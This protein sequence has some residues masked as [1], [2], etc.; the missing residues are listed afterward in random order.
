MNTLQSLDSLFGGE[1]D[2]SD[3]LI[4]GASGGMLGAAYFRELYYEKIKGTKIN[5]Q[6]K[7]Y[8]ENISKDLLQPAVL[9]FCYT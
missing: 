2:G 7:Q 1:V 9:F 4:N 3:H 6:D 8:A 5:L